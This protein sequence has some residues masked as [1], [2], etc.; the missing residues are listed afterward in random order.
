MESIIYQNQEI[1]RWDVGPST[2]LALPEKG[3]RLL[4]WHINM[5]DGS[6]RDIIHWPEQIDAENYT[7]T[8]GG[9]PI[10]FPFAGKC[11]DSGNEDHW[12]YGRKV[13]SMPQH[14]FAKNS[15]FRI[16]SMDQHGFEVELEPSE[17]VKLF[18]PFNYTF[19]VIYHFLELSLQISLVL[20]NEGREPIPWSAGIHPYFQIP[21]RKDLS[22]ADHKLSVDA[23]QVFQY[24]SGGMMKKSPNPQMISSLEDP[25]LINRVYYELKRPTAEVSLLNDEEPIKISEVGGAENG[26]RLTFVTWSQEGAPY[27]CVEPWMSPPNAP[28]NKTMRIVPPAGRDEFTIEIELA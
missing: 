5:S 28:E 26:S 11:Y 1:K 13:L 24:Q 20:E 21:W 15:N 22:L 12:R 14:G 23:K 18:Y 27:Y 19:T 6:V 3:A 10:L 8:H 9:I 4:N 17:E 25:S 7:R 2:F 16:R